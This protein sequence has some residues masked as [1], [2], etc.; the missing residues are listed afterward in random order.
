[1]TELTLGKIRH[2]QQISSEQGIFSIAALDHRDAF[3]EMLGKA[4][5]VE[6]LPWES[7][8]EEKVRM[9]RALA[10]H[11]SAVLL[12]PLYGVG[13]A[14]QRGALPGSVGLL[15][16]R[17]QSGYKPHHAGRITVLMDDW[18]S[19]AIK[20]VGSAAVKLLL[21]YHPDA[22]NARDQEDVVR[23]VAEECKTHDIPFLLEPLCYPLDPAQK[24]TDAD[25]AR[26]RPELVIESVRRLVPLGVDV[27]K[28][29]FPTDPARETDEGRMRAA[30]RQL[31]QASVAPWVLLSAGVNFEMF[32]MQVQIACEAGASGFV[33]GR[34]IWQEGLQLPD[35]SD[36]ERFYRTQAAVRL[37]ALKEI[38][39]AYGRPWYE[40]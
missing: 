14:I 12:D 4:I 2:L 36:R 40:H 20:R 13:P 38:A 35:P 10:P 15:V 32:K 39:A 33:A 21:Y 37:Q 34:A 8:A 23:R 28:A 11:V 22:P 29:E 26:I 16:A 25:F 30:C 1:M 31:S 3:V 18:D 5:E 6:Q 27:L 9:T 7:V 24:K 17:E 19:G